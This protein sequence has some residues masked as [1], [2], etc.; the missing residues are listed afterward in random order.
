VATA[1]QG[2]E[3]EMVLGTANR[4]MNSILNAVVSFALQASYRDRNS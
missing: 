1:M 3:A 4:I 2:L